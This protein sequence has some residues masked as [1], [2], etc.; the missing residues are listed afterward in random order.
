MHTLTKLKSS[1]S[2]LISLLI[3]SITFTGCR[4]YKKNSTTKAYEEFKINNYAKV[5]RIY[6]AVNDIILTKTDKQFNPILID[7]SLQTHGVGSTEISTPQHFSS[8]INNLQ[9]SDQ[10]LSK[11]NAHI[12]ILACFDEPAEF[13]AC[14]DLP[15]NARDRMSEPF[16]EGNSHY[17]AIEKQ[18]MADSSCK[19]NDN[20]PQ[21]RLNQRF[22]LADFPRIRENNYQ[23]ISQ[24]PEKE[25]EGKCVSILDNDTL[26][27]SMENYEKIAE[28]VGPNAFDWGTLAFSSAGCLMG[29]GHI[30]HRVRAT[31]MSKSDS[32][33]RTKA[34]I[35]TNFIRTYPAIERFNTVLLKIGRFNHI[36]Y[37][38]LKQY[39]GTLHG[40][41]L[42][43]VKN[44][45]ALSIFKAMKKILSPTGQNN[46][47]IHKALVSSGIGLIRMSPRASSLFGAYLVKP[48]QGDGNEEY[49]INELI[50][51]ADQALT[52]KKYKEDI[53]RIDRII[54][55][56][57]MKKMLE[58][59][60]AD[61]TDLAYLTLAAGSLFIP[62]LACLLVMQDVA[63]IDNEFDTRDNFI[64]LR[65]AITAARARAEVTINEISKEPKNH[66]YSKWASE[67]NAAKKIFS[68]D[69][70]KV[71]Q[72]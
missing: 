6:L 57:T 19:S 62:P 5:D 31:A 70:S 63:R 9:N 67:Y 25:R 49:S 8:L 68:T 24:L 53:D 30:V 17:L 21:I 42:E 56:D 2:M 39:Q 10:L 46:G 14:V 33:W 27:D 55:S 54:N 38:F 36:V 58:T 4:P 16:E 65:N 23:I 72:Q 52:N 22:R 50:D 61:D 45:F 15:S 48:Q 44:T 64:G 28:G 1:H 66:T 32:I 41:Q 47:L 13:D 51:N 71:V 40:A 43:K 34:R 35:I 26:V 11:S 60:H 3:A 18:T 12:Q 59:T 37:R 69:L 29:A 7:Q 20:K